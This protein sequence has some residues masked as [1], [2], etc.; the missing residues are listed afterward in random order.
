M[1]RAHGMP[2]P[3]VQKLQFFQAAVQKRVGAGL[4]PVIFLD[5]EKVAGR[6]PDINNDPGLP[7]RF[8]FYTVI[9]LEHRRSPCA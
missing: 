9:D 2:G 6:V 5:G 4:V 3:S 1:H 8:D 7:G